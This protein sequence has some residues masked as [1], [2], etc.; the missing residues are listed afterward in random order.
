MRISV[1]VTICSLLASCSL[2]Q[3]INE[4]AIVAGVSYSERDFLNTLH[5]S[6]F[7]QNGDI[8]S[9]RNPVVVCD[10]LAGNGTSITSRTFNL[11]FDLRPGETQ[12]SEFMPLFTGIGE[13][14]QGVDVRC[15]LKR[16]TRISA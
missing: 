1:F 10:L 15:R 9:I 11:Y 7:V 5:G 16:A 8:R 14:S 3:P 4:K 12:E 13:T 6:I 2:E